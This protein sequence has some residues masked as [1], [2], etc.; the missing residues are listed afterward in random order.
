MIL[1]DATM[2]DTYALVFSIITIA[3]AVCIL[4]FYLSILWR[5]LHDINLP[6]PLALIVIGVAAA[7]ELGGMTALSALVYIM[8]I[9]L[10]FIR[11]TKGPN[12]YGPDPLGGGE[13][14][15]VEQVFGG[16][17][18]VPAPKAPEALATQAG[19]NENRTL[20]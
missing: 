6:G 17:P 9:M 16:E 10:L 19:W 11:G 8:G 4:F 14:M 2:T 12:K 1:E 15:V 5:R 13:D 3:A 7:S 20:R 18:V